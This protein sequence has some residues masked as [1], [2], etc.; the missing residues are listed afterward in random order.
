MRLLPA[1]D[2]S[3]F[4]MFSVLFLVSILAS[5]FIG[6][7]AFAV[8]L[9]V[10]AALCAII[11]RPLEDGQRRQAYALFGIFALFGAG[12]LV[13][14]KIM[15][16]PSQALGA[17]PFLALGFLALY[18]IVKLYVVDWRAECKVIGYSEGYAIVEV[19]PSVMSAIPAGIIAVKSRPV[20]KGKRARLA[21]ERRLF[22]P[23]T[24]P[25][26]LESH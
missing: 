5:T 4:Q 21:F 10:F 24:K 8:T 25:V 3:R 23:A 6:E 16:S 22:G 11:S 2:I 26:G 20:A 7:A 9:L 18:V 12:A 14:G 17:M 15:S 19:A 1:D 13:A